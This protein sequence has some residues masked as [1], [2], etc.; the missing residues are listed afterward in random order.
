MRHD[1]LNRIK[2]VALLFTLGGLALIG[3]GVR[4]FAANVA[5]TYGPNGWRKGG[6]SADFGGKIGDGVGNGGGGEDGD[7]DGNDD[8]DDDCSRSG[9]AGANSVEYAISLGSAEFLENG[10]LR[11]GALEFYIYYDSVKHAEAYRRPEKKVM[12]AGQPACG[13][14]RADTSGRMRQ[15]LTRTLLTDFVDL[16]GG[17]GYK[18]SFYRIVREKPELVSDFYDVA[19]L[20]A[21]ALVKVVTVRNPDG[22]SLNGRFEIL[23]EDYHVIENAPRRQTL[24]WEEGV[25]GAFLMEKYAGKRGEPGAKLIKRIQIG[26]RVAI[27]KG[28]AIGPLV[29]WQHEPIGGGGTV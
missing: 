20:P 1:F 6:V 13:D 21:D 5:L 19:S 28:V 7:N 11:D 24:Y 29:A 27:N 25:D 9:R 15:V 14:V 3:E 18:I 17:N 16:P 12:M 22:G 10:W 23:E 8:E 26:E 4:L 2:A